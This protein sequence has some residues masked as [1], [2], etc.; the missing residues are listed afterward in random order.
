[1][2]IS[3]R[4]LK[5]SVTNLLLI[6][7][8]GFYM[9]ST[10]AVDKEH[11]IKGSQVQLDDILFRFSDIFIF[12][13]LGFTTIFWKVCLQVMHPCCWSSNFQIRVKLFSMLSSLKQFIVEKSVKGFCLFHVMLFVK[14]RLDSGFSKH[15]ALCKI[16]W[17]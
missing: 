17:K 3:S 6:V 4:L 13:Q 9:G 11:L 8:F 5:S 1:M 16:I 7:W 14:K 2:G 12:D 10:W 15:K